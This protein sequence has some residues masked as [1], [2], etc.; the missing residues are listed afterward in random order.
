MMTYASL[1]NHHASVIAGDVKSITPKL[2]EHIAEAFG[3][4][5]SSAANPDFFQQTFETLT[6]DDSR[7][8]REIHES[9]PFSPDIPRIFIIEMYGATREAQNALLKVIEEPQPD[10]YFFFVVPSIDI[11]LPT[12]RSRVQIIQIDGDGR[13]VEGAAGSSI[14]DSFV[15]DF[16]KIPLGKKIAYVDELAADISDGKKAKHEAIAF[17]NGL[18]KTFYNSSSFAAELREMRDTFAI[19]SRTR[20]YMNDRAPSVK[21][22]LEY[23]ALSV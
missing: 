22:L 9:K 15:A 6:I 14:E 16:V 21:M 7:R 20:D 8:I 10:N 1:R 12:V 13:T 4:S 17:L 11:F 5:V 18:E 19:I 2:R 23:V 3:A